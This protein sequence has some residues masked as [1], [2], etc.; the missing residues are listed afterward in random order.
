MH[1]DMMKWK[2]SVLDSKKRLAVPVM[3][4]PGMALRGNTVLATVTNPRFH[5]EAVQA[6][7]Q[8]YPTGASTMIMDLSV[9]AEA[10]G[11]TIRF[12]DDEVPSVTARCVHDADSI[13]QL[14]IP[15]LTQARVGQWLEASRL[16]ANS[17]S[18]R[19]VFAGC[20]G[21]FSL[22]GRLFDVT[23][24]MT[25][26]L[27]EPDSV[28]ALLEKCTQFLMA[29]VKAFKA[30]GANGVLI[31]EPVA[32]V[33]SADHCTEFSSNFIKRIVEAVQ[34]D[35]FLVILHNC[36]DTDTLVSSMLSTGAGGLHFGNRCN[37]VKALEQIPG[38]T[39]VFGNIDPVAVFKSGSPKSVRSATLQLL[40]ATKGFSNFVL[41]SGCDV[42]PHVPLENIDAFFAAL[43]EFNAGP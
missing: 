17:I 14:A 31:A 36:G 13:E 11:A 26:I 2:Q 30:A 20:I 1:R 41:S 19:P 6:V 29:Y 3:T 21:P 4:H 34:D 25:A 16:A 5:F 9:E 37:I 12:A 43:S 32:G 7:A 42:P 15:G 27:T 39:L 22:A 24:V 8:Q 35:S 18:D 23:E 33:L 28:L 10:F 38:D 40:Q